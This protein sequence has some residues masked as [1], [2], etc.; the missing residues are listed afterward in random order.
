MVCEDGHYG[1]ALL[2]RHPVTAVRRIDLGVSGR[3]PRGALDADLDV[4]GRCVQVVVTHF[5]LSAAERRQQASRLLEAVR[6]DV[7]HPILLLGDFNEW[8]PGGGALRMLQPHFVRSP[9]LPTF[10][11][12]RPMLALDR[13]WIRSGHAL[14]GVRVHRS[15]AARVASDHL[16]LR[17]D[18]AL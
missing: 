13:I 10:P 6:L 5:G 1:N 4:R 9:S 7:E 8:L 12:L 2:T 16:P 18:I 15:P 11:S 17:A 3:E 14:A